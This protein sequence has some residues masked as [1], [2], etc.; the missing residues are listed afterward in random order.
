MQAQPQVQ[1]R[2]P[3]CPQLLTFQPWSGHCRESSETGGPASGWGGYRQ[4]VRLVRGAARN[5]AVE[6]SHQWRLRKRERGLGRLAELHQVE[7]RKAL[8]AGGLVIAAALHSSSP[9]SGL[10]CIGNDASDSSDCNMRP[11]EP[12]HARSNRKR[13]TQSGNPRIAHALCPT[14]YGA[15]CMAPFPAQACH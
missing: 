7:C 8:L 10:M 2:S 15:G 13:Q 12:S 9:V 4:C 3:P 11:T 5:C 1:L 14:H 6:G